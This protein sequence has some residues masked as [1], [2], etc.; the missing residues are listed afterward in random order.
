MA[1]NILHEGYGWCQPPMDMQGKALF[2]LQTSYLTKPLFRSP[3][4]MSLPIAHML[5]CDRL[6]Q[7]SNIDCIV[8]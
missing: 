5:N 8:N 4:T 6:K 7:R 1:I 2:R 3:Y